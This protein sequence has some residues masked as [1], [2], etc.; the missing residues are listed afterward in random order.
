L[1]KNIFLIKEIT[2]NNIISQRKQETERHKLKSSSGYASK[3]GYFSKKD[4]K[5]KL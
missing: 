4:S 2:S 5:R 3:N 1:N